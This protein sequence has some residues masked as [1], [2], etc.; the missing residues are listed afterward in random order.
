[1][2]QQYS[3]GLELGLR[4][5]RKGKGSMA[6]NLIFKVYHENCVHDPGSTWEQKG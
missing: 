4:A 2:P 3:Q 6:K 1:M 5:Y